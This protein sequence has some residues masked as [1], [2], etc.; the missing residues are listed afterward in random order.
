MNKY[1]DNILA[2]SVIAS[3]AIKDTSDLIRVLGVLVITVV[4]GGKELT[5]SG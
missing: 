4:F 1:K 5:K 3:V 2:F